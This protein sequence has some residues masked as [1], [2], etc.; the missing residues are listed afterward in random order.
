MGDDGWKLELKWQLRQHQTSVE[1][2]KAHTTT[3]KFDKMVLRNRG[4]PLAVVALLVSMIEGVAAFALLTSSSQSTCTSLD[5]VRTRGLERNVGSATPEGACWW[6][7]IP[8]MELISS[9]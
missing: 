7:S 6:F 4:R 1:F 3:A 2:I 5:M 8:D 9:L